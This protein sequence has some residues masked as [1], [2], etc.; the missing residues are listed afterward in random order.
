MGLCDTVHNSYLT[1]RKQSVKYN[2]FYS[3]KIKSEQGV[4]QGTVL[5]LSEYLIAKKLL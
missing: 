2:H 4:P 3:S 5:L 1:N